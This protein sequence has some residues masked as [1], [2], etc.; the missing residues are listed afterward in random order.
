MDGLRVTH[1][2]GGWGAGPLACV[3]CAAVIVNGLSSLKVS[4]D[5]AGTLMAP[6]LVTTWV[7]A[8]APAPAAAPMAA[9]LPWP[10][11]AP[12]MAPSAAPPTVYSPVRLLTQIPDFPFWLISAV[13]I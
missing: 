3:Y 11:I 8:P 1:R 2:I 9:P 12:M 4:T 5:S 10:A 6:P 7:S 13:S